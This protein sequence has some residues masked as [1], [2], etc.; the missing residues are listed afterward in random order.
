M[1]V[2]PHQGRPAFLDRYWARGTGKTWKALR[3]FPNRLETLADEVERI[4]RADHLFFARRRGKDLSRFELQRLQ[5]NCI[6][7]PTMIRIY[8]EALRERNA[9][10]SVATPPS[11]RSEGLFQFTELVKWLSGVYHD[12]QISELLN[13]VAV[14]LGERKQFD[15]ITVA[16]ARFRRQKKIPQT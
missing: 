6:Q 9:T 10:V 4:N 5:Q 8:A 7:V 15:A 11:G 14:A 12:Q 2:S 16:Q 3:E 1:A 13:T